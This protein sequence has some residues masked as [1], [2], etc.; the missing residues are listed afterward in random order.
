MPLSKHALINR[1]LTLSALPFIILTHAI[2]PPPTVYPGCGILLNTIY[3]FGGG[4][5]EASLDFI[6]SNG[7]FSFNI[8]NAIDTRH[9]FSS[10]EKIVTSGDVQPEPNGAM[11][12]YAIP[13]YNR[14]VVDGGA[15]YNNGTGLTHR[16][17]VFDAL[18]VEWSEIQPSQSP[19]M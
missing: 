18:T 2:T 1:L 17:I 7:F 11:S 9:N 5:I 12:F 16:T 4:Q 13:K 8:T 19:Q 10:W 3:C 14:L 15:G 6:P